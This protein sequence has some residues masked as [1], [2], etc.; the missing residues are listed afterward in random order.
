[1]QHMLDDTSANDDTIEALLDV[2]KTQ[3]QH[4]H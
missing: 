4:S 1:M 3:F 2:N